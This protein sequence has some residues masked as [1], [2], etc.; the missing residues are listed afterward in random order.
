MAVRIEYLLV[1]MLALLLVSI[2]GINPSSKLEK[3]V[4]G[5]KEIEFKNFFLFD[6]KRDEPAQIMFA[7]KTVRYQNYLEVDD[8]DLRDELGYRLVATKAI[9]ADEYVYMDKGIN[10]L[11]DDGLKFS[12]K[13]LNYNVKTKEIKTGKPF[14]MEF[15]SSIIQGQNLILNMNTKRLSADNIEAKIVFLETNVTFIQE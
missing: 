6:I 13:S 1:L 7:S 9:Y 11:R 14:L 5:E 12:T 4:K 15:N 10:I 2:L 8:I 3:S